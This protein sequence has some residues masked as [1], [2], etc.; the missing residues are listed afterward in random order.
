MWL[1]KRRETIPLHERRLPFC[2]TALGLV[3]TALVAFCSVSLLA[4]GPGN[5]SNQANWNNQGQ[6]W[7]QR[8]HRVWPDTASRIIPYNDQVGDGGLTTQGNGTPFTEAQIQFFATH[9]AGTQK[10]TTAAAETLRQ[11]N[12]NF[13][14]MHYRLGQALGYGICDANGNPTDVDPVGIFDVT[15]I[16]EWPTVVPEY[17]TD[18][19]LYNNYFYYYDNAKVYA[20]GAQ[21]YLMNIADPGWRAAYSAAVLKELKDNQDDAVFADFYSIPNYL[22]AYP[23]LPALDIPFE[24]AWAKMEYSFND[25]MRAQLHGRWPWI[26]NA[27]SWVTTRDPDIEYSNVDG[28]M[29]ED[30]A[31][32]GN[33]N[34][35]ATADWVTQMDR[36]LSITETNRILIGQTYVAP[37]G[38][39]S[40]GL[41]ERLF[42][43][44]SYLLV[45]GNHTYLNLAAI[46][47]TIEW[48]PEYDIDLGPPTD[49]LPK[50]NDIT[51]YW[52]A[53]WGVYV[54]HYAHGMVLVNS[55]NA[56]DGIAPT[57]ITLDKTYYEVVGDVATS[58]DVPVPANGIPDSNN[59]LLYQAV[60]GLTVCNDC[61]AI[62][63]DHP[64]SSK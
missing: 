20:C 35:L 9:Y 56:Q 46:G 43:T 59:K 48:F 62:L 38:N 7:Q 27:G 11:Y 1:Q 39:S 53:T 23:S 54:R 47:E 15:Y 44:G 24:D 5:D 18:P 52:N 32:Y 12:P 50:N 6:G 31:D 51:K 29:I 49:P 40:Y 22:G 55:I 19:S 64:P 61:A 36:A 41:P 60:K 63:L 8:H 13:L 3:A 58:A 42:V 25:Y 17:L 37:Y 45:K 16:P 57:P 26:P 2:G 10:M 33:A 34:F 28:V 21:N 4:Q 30:F 14:I